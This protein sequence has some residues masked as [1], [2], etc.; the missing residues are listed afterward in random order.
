MNRKF[1]LTSV[2]NLC[3]QIGKTFR[4]KVSK[5]MTTTTDISIFSKK[6]IYQFLVS[7]YFTFKKT[8]KLFEVIAGTAYP[9]ISCAYL[10]SV[11]GEKTYLASEKI[12][13]R[14][15]SICN[16]FNAILGNTLDKLEYY[17]NVDYPSFI[18]EVESPEFQILP[19]YFIILSQMNALSPSIA[20]LAKSLDRYCKKFIEAHI[21]PIFTIVTGE[22]VHATSEKKMQQKQQKEG[23]FTSVAKV[24]SS[25]VIRGYTPMTNYVEARQKEEEAKRIEKLRLQKLHKDSTIPRPKINPNPSS[26]E[27]S[28]FL[29]LQCIDRTILLL[30]TIAHILMIFMIGERR[31]LSETKSSD[32]NDSED[33]FLMTPPSPESFPSSLSSLAPSL[34]SSIHLSLLTLPHLSLPLSLAVSLALLTPPP[35]CDICLCKSICISMQYAPLTA[36][37]GMIRAEKERKRAASIG[38]TAS[39]SGSSSMLTSSGDDSLCSI[40]RYE[41][42]HAFYS[43]VSVAYHGYG[44]SLSLYCILLKKLLLSV[45]CLLPPN[46][47]E[48][49]KKTN[50]A[51]SLFRT[52]LTLPHSRKSFNAN[53]YDSKD[54]II[55]SGSASSASSSF[56][57]TSG[58]YFHGSSGEIPTISSP[59]SS[60]SSPASSQT[61][62]GIVSATIIRL[63]TAAL[64]HVRVSFLS[65]G[66]SSGSLTTSTGSIVDRNALKEV[67]RTLSSI[68]RERPDSLAACFAAHLDI[69][70]RE[71][72]LRHGKPT[73]GAR[74]FIL[75]KLFEMLGSKKIFLECNRIFLAHRLLDGCALEGEKRVIACIKDIC[76]GTYITKEERMLADIQEKEERWSQSEVVSKQ[77]DEEKGEEKREGDGNEEVDLRVLNSAAWMGISPSADRLRIPHAVKGKVESII[78]N[79][80]HKKWK[81]KRLHVCW[82]FGTVVLERY[83]PKTGKPIS[84]VC[85]VLFALVLMHIEHVSSIQDLSRATGISYDELPSILNDL[86][87]NN[88]IQCIVLKEGK[89]EEE[90][91]EDRVSHDAPAFMWYG[92]NDDIGLSQV[93]IIQSPPQTFELEKEEETKEKMK[94]GD[95]HIQRKSLF[96]KE[97]DKI[98]AD[99][100]SASKIYPCL[101]QSCV[102]ACIMN[103]LKKNT[104]NSIPMTQLISVVKL[105]YGE[106]GKKFVKK[107]V[108]KLLGREFIIR[109]KNGFAYGE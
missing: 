25:K 63:A 31:P 23:W 52:Q 37:Q 83:I 71:Q 53:G 46:C 50:S 86:L 5:L 82:D 65:S 27:E 88:V 101:G 20:I 41:K 6:E 39:A 48:T 84:I 15:I 36:V 3:V 21:N 96:S 22:D 104:G 26:D 80:M 68:L 73:S 56:N 62:P 69:E 97:I 1:N 33:R 51:R 59:Y 28:I 76:G 94:E 54:D 7:F 38:Q 87:Y 32:S 64:R 92:F 105:K 95:S 12:D 89:K 99:S 18:K 67:N 60:L 49:V 79:G 47:A 61:T 29:T 35:L 55:T 11:F 81:K 9:Q 10:L 13:G 78:A 102:E 103:L 108:D 100:S 75:M 40:F 90:E 106:E 98:S 8:A 4:N 109:G 70:L 14:E 19:H 34:F 107:A 91:E 17:A 77:K 66:G 2:D 24:I 44:E 57:P 74:L 30:C 93:R 72:S 16:F 85:N 45:V 42:L 43:H 58:S